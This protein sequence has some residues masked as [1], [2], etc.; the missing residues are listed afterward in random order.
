[1]IT[2]LASVAHGYDQ[3]GAPWYFSKGY[4][5]AAHALAYG[6]LG[7]AVAGGWG[8]IVTPLALAWWPVFRGRKQAQV[9]L[10]KM[11]TWNEPHPSYHDVLRAHY[12]TGWLT[13]LALYLFNY[14][15][16][17]D[18]VNNGR[19]WDCRRP[20]EFATGLTL[21]VVLSGLLFLLR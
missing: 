6:G 9:E 21:D 17:P 14:T 11:D 8:L 10:Q 1:M 3:A 16:H 20:S 15:R 13:M 18:L 5:M 19:F 2:A 7:F 4:I 12:Y